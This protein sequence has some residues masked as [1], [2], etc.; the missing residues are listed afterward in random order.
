MAEAGDEPKWVEIQKK[1]F[2]KWMNNHLRKKGY[3]AVANV[4][5]DFEDGI[6]LMRLVN[7]LYDKPIPKHNP[8]PKMRPH[9]LD[10]LVKALDMVEQAEIKTN[11]LKTTH[12]LDKDLKMI[13]GM[14]WAII[15]DYAIKGIS[16]EEATAKEGLLLWCRKKTAGYRDIDPP[17]IKN[18][19]NDWKNGLAFCALIHR[20]RPDLLNY[21]SLDAKND[22]ENLE[23][24][25]S[26]A[27]EKL[28][29]PRLLD[30]ED[31]KGT[32]DEKSVMTY[33]AEYFHRFA[34]QDQKENSARRCA[35]F[36]KFIRDM[37]SRE[38]EY[39]RRARASLA[40]V[41][42]NKQRFEDYKFGD[43]LAEA[44]TYQAELRKF[45]VEGR[46]Q[47][48][49]ER[50]DLEMLFAEIQTEL[51]VNSRAPYTPP[52]GLSPDDI[53][54]AFDGLGKAQ[55]GYARA[56][57]DNRFRFVQKADTTL[58]DDKK[59]EIE[60]SF[61]HFDSNKSQS[62]DKAEFK[63]ALSA[64][65]VFFSS[66]QELDATFAQ[67]SGGGA[68]VTKEQY[69]AYVENKYK[70]I[71]TPEQIKESFRAVADGAAY[72]TPDQLNVRPLTKEDVEYLK[73]AMPPTSGGLDYGAFVDANF[74]TS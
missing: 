43:T 70:D 63:A 68:A 29:I 7:A 66:D 54:S 30:V 20:H 74:V 59:K 48:E 46:P 45:V 35:K 2:T 5:D 19:K 26:I 47:Q 13:L 39:E 40:W 60:D 4:K 15:L 11:F 61:K 28:G 33:V 21:D 41:A 71:D 25:F 3:P 37:K 6:N 10:N 65:S 44:Q 8:Q 72:I 31:L 64:M 24:A 56:V 62:L 51:K 42:E 1:T 55:K 17:G 12:L 73:S 57:R 50:M 27:E 14:I 58:S 23:L 34:S 52:E 32:P 36:L 9:K 22:S 16:V 67:V 69:M 38:D 49:G 53:Q 18:F